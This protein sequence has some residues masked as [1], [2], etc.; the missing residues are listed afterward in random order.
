MSTPTLNTPH[1][2]SHEAYRII[3]A[4]R[5]WF[6]DNSRL[7]PLGVQ[8]P[9]LA[10][11]LGKNALL[12]DATL[13]RGNTFKIRGA[14]VMTDVLAKMG[15]KRVKTTSA[16]NH[17]QGTAHSASRYGLLADICLP[18]STPDTKIDP[19][20]AFPNVTVHIQG[21]TY[22]ETVKWMQNQSTFGA[23]LPA[24]DDINIMR[25]QGTIV[26]D[27]LQQYRSATGKSHPAAFV[28]PVGG[29]GLLG[30]AALQ[31]EELG[32]SKQVKLFGVE[33]T[34]SDSLSRTLEHGGILTP[35][36]TPNTLFGGS[37]VGLTGELTSA[38]IAAAPNV[39]IVTTTDD[40][41][42]TVAAGYARDHFASG[43]KHAP[44][45]PTA[46]QQFGVAQAIVAATNSDVV[47]VG[48]GRNAP[49][50]SLC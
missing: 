20:R 18:T 49:L 5:T 25:G 10:R 27:A 38:V 45:E 28:M 47:F 12:F 17:A 23:N 1:L 13:N 15:I 24:F 26:F 40:A 44:L 33:A 2:T 19:L 3:D 43:T 22:D 21:N 6:D 35:A 8:F 31:L 36:T 48:T 16:G 41:V 11:E 42:R 39:E 34:G 32:L 50:T 37:C 9:T 14:Q 29:G 30:G 7:E 4:N 46:L